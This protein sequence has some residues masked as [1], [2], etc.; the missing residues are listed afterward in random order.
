MPKTIY[1]IQDEIGR[2]PWRPGFSSHWV[3][4]RDDHCYLLPYYV[5]F[6]KMPDLFECNQDHY[7]ACGCRTIK[8]LKRWFIK[9]EYKTLLKYGYRA[10]VLDA[11]KIIAE[12]DKQCVFRRTK[13]LFNGAKTFDLY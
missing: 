2:G 7:V 9:Q 11:E 4:S 5:E 12:S 13:P 1:R 6:M 10:V 3:I 8:Q